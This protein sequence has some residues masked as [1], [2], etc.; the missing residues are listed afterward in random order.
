MAAPTAEEA[1]GGR[2]GEGRLAGGGGGG[3][4]RAVARRWRSGGGGAPPP[5]DPTE[6][7]ADSGRQR[8]A[9]GRIRG[10]RRRAVDDFVD[11]LKMF[12]ICG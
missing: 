11:F 6:G 2:R 5:L 8:G 3:R 10:R 7:D 9:A 1:A 12:L 4:A